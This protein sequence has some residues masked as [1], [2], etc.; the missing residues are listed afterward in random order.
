M[1][2][3]TVTRRNMKTIL[4]GVLL[5]LSLASVCTATATLTLNPGNG[6][7][8]GAPGQSLGWG[9][10]ISD[11]TNWLLVEGTAFCTS[12]NTSTDTFPSVNPGPPTPPHP[13]TST[14]C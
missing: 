8:V 7:L 14:H 1:I 2:G 10:T 13:T 9:F 12:S 6:A 3:F 4:L 11:N 5:V